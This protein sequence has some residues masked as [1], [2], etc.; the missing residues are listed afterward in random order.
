MDSFL[1]ISWTE[2]MLFCKILAKQ[3]VTAKK[4]NISPWD[5]GGHIVAGILSHY[6]CDIVPKTHQ[7]DV[8]VDDIACT[9]ETIQSFGGYAVAVLIMRRTCSPVPDFWAKQVIG[10]RYVLFPWQDEET[11]RQQIAEK[12]FRTCN[13]G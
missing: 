12:G 10:P 7:T 11:E 4:I 3:L 9:G 13:G 1:R 5:R 6:G 2:T 8:I